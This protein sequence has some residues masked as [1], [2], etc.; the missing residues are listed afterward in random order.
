MDKN[1]EYV[2]KWWNDKNIELVKINEKIYALHGWNGES[3]FNCWEVA[4]NLIDVIDEKKEYIIKP[5]YKEIGEDEFELIE[6]E[7]VG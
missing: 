3:Y 1:F 2:G 7:I 6:Y 5:V 4:E